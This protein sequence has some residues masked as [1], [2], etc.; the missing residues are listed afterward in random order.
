ML[1][2]IFLEVLLISH[3]IEHTTFF[4]MAVLLN[5]SVRENVPFFLCS[6]K[7]RCAKTLL[8]L[9]VINGNSPYSNNQSW[10]LNRANCWTIWQNCPVEVGCFKTGEAAIIKIKWI[11]LNLIVILYGGR[12]FIV[13]EAAIEGMYRRTRFSR[14][15]SFFVDTIVF[16]VWIAADLTDLNPP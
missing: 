9:A 3:Q 4:L 6:Q 16:C 5:M 8:Y 14:K 10:N 1:C 2:Y 15:S 12:V 11:Y 7:E 13:M